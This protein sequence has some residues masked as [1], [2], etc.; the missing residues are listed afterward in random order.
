[1][2]IFYSAYY[3]D[4]LKEAWEYKMICKEIFKKYTD[5]ESIDG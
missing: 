5:K 1:M 2:M 3:S 4:N